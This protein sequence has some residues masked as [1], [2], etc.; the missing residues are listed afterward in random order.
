MVTSSS[1]SS[2][3]SE[4][5]RDLLTQDVLAGARELLGWRLVLRLP[6]GQEL[7]AQI[8]ET[9]AYRTPDDPGSHA[10]RGRTPR[11]AIMFG[12]AGLAYTY[13]VYGN[14]WMLNVTAHEEG[15]AAAVLI[16]AAKPLFDG[17][18]KNLMNGPGKLCRSLGINGASNGLDLLAPESILRLEPGQPIKGVLFGPRI[19]LAEGKGREH[20]WRYARADML[21]HVSKPINS[22]LP[23]SK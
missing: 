16:R 10:H 22:L 6:D 1:E 15:N 2:K 11:N 13:F 18:P 9:E 3:R 7:A 17:E 19:G 14:H 23:E 8:V 4:A 12:P 21:A 20:L 5:L